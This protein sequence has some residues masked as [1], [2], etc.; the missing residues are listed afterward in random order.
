[1]RHIDSPGA[2]RELGAE[3]LSPRRR[4]LILISSD[5]SGAFLYDP[6]HVEREIGT[7]VDVVTISTGD[8][9]Y[10]LQSVLP[11]KANVY[12][13]AA[14]SYPPDFHSAP[15]WWRSALRFPK[16]HSV[17]EL[18]EDALAQVVT[19]IAA[20][21]E[22]AR[23]ARATVERVS[24]ATGNV[25]RLDDGERVM[26]VADRL[27]SQAA[28]AEGLEVGSSV[29]GWLL[30]KDLS[31]EAERFNPD[32]LVDGSVTLARV[33]KVTDRRV[34]LMLHPLSP[35]Y[36]LR[37][38]DVIPGVDDG[39][40]EDVS[41]ADVVREGETVRTRV[42]RSAQGLA[43]SL[44]NVDP[45]AVIVEPQSLLKGGPAWLQEG[46]HQEPKALSAPAAV[47]APSE[48]VVTVTSPSDNPAG[49]PLS[50][51]PF[52]G[53]VSA[54]DLQ[55][56][57]DEL[58]GLRGT[59]GRLGHELREGTDLE[60]L[61]RLRD[62]ITTLSAQLREEREKS[63]ERSLMIVR[64]TREV[65]DARSVKTQ[66]T[67][68]SDT[69]RARQSLWPDRESWIREEIRRAW[70]QR[71]LAGEKHRYPLQEGFLV[72]PS[73][74]SSLEILDDGQLDKMLRAAVYVLIRRAHEVP[75]LDLHE[76][77]SGMGGEDAPVVRADGA[78]SW[79]VAIEQK[80]AS[81]RRLHYWVLPGGKIELSRVG[82]HD[83][84]TP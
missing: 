60:T 84:Y 9:T 14:R 13:G 20:P 78:K 75:S 58:A 59:I 24:G 26:I 23:W 73:F 40:N 77:R 42:T 1:M 37:R 65:R 50:G 57:R 76:L 10:A 25:A 47:Q 52:V 55:E 63:A 72:G 29:E 7:D 62:E 36:P 56:V 43:L 11:E 61:D 67:H 6:E 19:T 44:V 15:D 54:R 2:A 51:L 8:T 68:D 28:L 5:E 69:P 66:V 30:G 70:V 49:P 71:V 31:P 33:V 16:H 64:L 80:T 79:R 17:E 4:P 46:L 41:C 21:V 12:G 39:E 18:I 38:R 22:R 35:E 3:I 32:R 82:I 34:N 45:E 53:A 27:T 48:P 74:V 81:A 83:D